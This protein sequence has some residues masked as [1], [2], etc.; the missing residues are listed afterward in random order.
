[1]KRSTITVLLLAAFCPGQ[2]ALAAEPV[3]LTF[4]TYSGYFV[5]NKFEPDAAASFVVVNDQKE[6]DAVFAPAF[7]MRDKSHRLPKDSFKSTTVL[8]AVKRGN[9]FVEYKIEGVTEAKGVV[10]LRY[11][12]TSIKHNSTTF[13]CPLIV[14]IPKQKY[15]T[16]RFIE[17]GKVVE[18]LEIDPATGTHGKD[19]SL[20]TTT[21]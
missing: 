1:M 13:A 7:V 15:A 14:S 4:D 11:S 18:K 12:T 17:D 20:K 3:K 8:A 6:F 5:S 21:K 19:A 9:A 2:Q 16:I 10:E